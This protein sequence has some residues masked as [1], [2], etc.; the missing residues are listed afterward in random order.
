MDTSHQWN[1]H[2]IKPPQKF[3]WNKMWK[4]GKDVGNQPN[5]DPFPLVDLVL[6]SDWHLHLVNYQPI[7]ELCLFFLWCNWLIVLSISGMMVCGGHGYWVHSSA[8]TRTLSLQQHIHTLFTYLIS[9][10][11]DVRAYT[12][13]HVIVQ[14]KMVSKKKNRGSWS[15]LRYD[16]TAT[17]HSLHLQN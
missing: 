10:C 3:Q 5:T 2:K 16:I 13:V 15:K 17:S 8:D 1:K 7:T 14:L 11:S 6:T 12:F 9:L 4:C